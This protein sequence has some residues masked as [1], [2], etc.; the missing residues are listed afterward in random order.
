[1]IRLIRYKTLNDVWHDMALY[2]ADAIRVHGGGGV[3]LKS[4]QN[5]FVGDR[6]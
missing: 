6:A 5:V 1:M 4:V 2:M 3:L